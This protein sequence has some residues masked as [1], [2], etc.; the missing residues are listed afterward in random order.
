MVKSNFIIYV[1]NSDKYVLSLVLN[2]V[3]ASQPDTGSSCRLNPHTQNKQPI[4]VNVLNR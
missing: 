2:E 4:M 3:V 1:V